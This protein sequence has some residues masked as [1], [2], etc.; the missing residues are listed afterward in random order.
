[1]NPTATNHPSLQR[2]RKVLHVLNSA[3]GGAALSTIGL[4]EA[5]W[6][7]GIEACAV[8]HDSGNSAERALIQEACRG[9]A[10][11]TTLYW[12]N[13]KT[14]APLWKRPL[15]EIRDLLKTGCARRS[16]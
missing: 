14:R 3:S 7:E 12:S 11:F 1:M 6:K 16:A 5:F 15:L 8:C 13:K 10:I 2:P 9:Q 4:M